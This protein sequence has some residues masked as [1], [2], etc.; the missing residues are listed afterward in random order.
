LDLLLRCVGELVPLGVEEL[1]AVVLRRVVRG[2]DDDAEVEREQRDSRCRK[3][4]AEDCVAADGDDAARER[5][6]ELDTGCARVPA[7]EHLRRTRP[8]GGGATETLD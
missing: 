3:D 2:G 1:D 6:L 8:R 5:L 7:D 4:T